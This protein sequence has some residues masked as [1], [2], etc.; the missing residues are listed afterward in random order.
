MLISDIIHRLEILAPI[1]RQE[2]YDNSGIQVGLTNVECTGALVS[3]DVT[4]DVIN[5]AIDLGCNLVISHHPLLFHPLKRITGD[6]AVEQCVMMALASGITVY[7]AHTCLDNSPGGVSSMMASML[8]LQ[9]VQVLEPQSGRMLNLT[10]YVPVDKASALADALYGA[11]AGVTKLYDRSSYAMNGIGTWRPLPDAP[12]DVGDEGVQYE[13]E[14]TRLELI[15]P[16]WKRHEVEAALLANHPYVDP[17]YDFHPVN[18][19]EYGA[20]SGAI[21]LLPEAAPVGEV[22]RKIKDAFGSPMARCSLI[23]LSAP[24]S[25]VALC[26]GSGAYL[27]PKAIAAGAQ[28][29]I[30]SDTKY[31]DF[32]DYGRRI[33]IVDIGHYESEQCTKSIFYHLIREIFPNFAVRYS[34]QDINPIK[35]M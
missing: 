22:V 2:D 8:G 21:G 10:V 33:M 7:S 6:S 20:G 16:S 12:H 25:K 11:G 18:Q 19:N 34:Q 26:G 35:Y 5:E 32:V 13:V 27:I 23:P 15:L 17:V 14:E 30:T 28:L 29:F 3:V 1:D 24:I 31:H 4:P 9:D